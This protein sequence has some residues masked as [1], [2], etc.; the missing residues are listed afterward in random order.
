MQRWRDFLLL[1]YIKDHKV[2]EVIFIRLKLT[3]TILPVGSQVWTFLTKSLS[4]Y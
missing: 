1:N 3:E 4:Q 2:S